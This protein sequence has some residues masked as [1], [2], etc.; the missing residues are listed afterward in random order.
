MIQLKNI[1]LRRGNKVVL[2]EA[3]LTVHPG[4]RVGVVGKNGVGKSSL[5]GLL[6]AELHQDAGECSLPAAW[7]IAHVAQETP[8]LNSSALDYALDGDKEL[9][10]LE[11]A[12][13]DAEARHDGEAIGHL[14]DEMARIDGY[15]AP[16]RAA[17]LLA[18]LGFSETAQ[19][20][21]VASFSGGWRMRLNLAQAL[22]CRSD[23]LLL[24]EPTNHLDLEAVLWLEDWLT[25]YPGTLLLIS[26]DRD[27]L[28]TVTSHIAEV[29]TGK[30]TLYTGGYSD[31]ERSRAERLAREAALYSAQ[32][33][34]IA[35]LENFI[36]RFKAKATKARQAQSRVKALERLERVACAQVDSPFSFEFRDPD[37]QPSPLVRL[38]GVSIGYG[39]IPLLQ[40][41]ELSVEAGA[42]VGLLGPNGVGKSTFIKLLAG[43]LAALGGKVTRAKELRVGYFAQHQLETLRE[44][45]SPLWH[46]N[47][48]APDVR[49]QELRDFLG[50]FDF[51]GEMVSSPVG[52]MSGGEKARLALALIVWQRPNLLLL[53]EPTNH[54]DLDM[55]AALTLALQDYSGALVVVSHDRALIEATTDSFYVVGEGTVKVFEGDLEEYR[56]LRLEQDRARQQAQ[57]QE[58]QA[59]GSNT[60]VVDRKAQ[61]RLEAE[62]R[63]RLSAQRKPLEKQLAQYEKTL[64]ALQA[65]KSTLDTLLADEA[66]YQPE[67]KTQLQQAL[68]RQGEVSAALAE[69]EEQWLMVQMELEALS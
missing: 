20:Q 52:P 24:D 57:R 30:I 26:H 39:D 44:A 3:Q 29:A 35:H 2:Q 22:M 4:Q 9:R 12:L 55:R 59:D 65:E 27:F 67:Q 17:R 32:Q 66:M 15:A 61:K 64:T 16:A 33:K 18:G 49:E 63:Q 23:L 34:Q 43:E 37:S 31:Y 38:E 60:P 41:L 50:G 5:F 28:D 42:R 54:L 51:R 21:P 7:V 14:H 11:V 56:Q 19:Q 48:I 13:A 47:R 46:L 68:K 53:D 10:Q 58:Q 25:R 36:R 6:R 1:T 8:A 40:R 45:E 69:A 62:A